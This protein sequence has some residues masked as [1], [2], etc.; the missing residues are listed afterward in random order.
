MY[1]LC[2][3]A[4]KISGKNIQVIIL[5]QRG[6]KKKKKGNNHSY[7]IKLFL[8]E[9]IRDWKIYKTHYTPSATWG[10]QKTFS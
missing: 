6:D 10:E 5:F 3:S 9:S 4:I 1:I 8:K 7:L 2:D